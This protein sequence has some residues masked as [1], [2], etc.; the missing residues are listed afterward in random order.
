MKCNDPVRQGYKIVL[1]PCATTPGK[2]VSVIQ[3]PATTTQAVVVTTPPVSHAAHG[4][5]PFTGAQLGLF[6]G[7]GFG[8]V[9][10]GTLLRH[11]RW[12]E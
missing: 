8:L 6:A 5:L 7:V 1:V 12:S 2:H 4:Q 9:A 11:A 3:T 10:L